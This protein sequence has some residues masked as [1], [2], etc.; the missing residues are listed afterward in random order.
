M[1]SPRSKSTAT[2][3][4]GETPSGQRSR[5]SEAMPKGPTA[6]GG[7]L[8][9]WPSRSQPCGERHEVARLPTARVAAGRLW[10]VQ[11]QGSLGRIGIVVPV[12]LL[13]LTGCTSTASTGDRAAASG[14]P[15]DTASSGAPAAHPSATPSVTVDPRFPPRLPDAQKT[16]ITT[17][18]KKGPHSFPVLPQIQ[19]GTLEVAVI[20]SGSGTIDP[21]G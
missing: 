19:R 9:R 4:D 21:P 13:A 10:T 15:V 12:V 8:R 1:T 6:C 18:G 7:A 11:P 14:T 3:T 5:V 17:G 16:F 20:C 2:I